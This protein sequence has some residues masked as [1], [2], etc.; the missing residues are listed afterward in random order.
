M[1]RTSIKAQLFIAEDVRQELD[2]KLSLIGF[3]S[4]AVIVADAGGRKIS[5]ESPIGL[6][7]ITFLVT[8]SH[9]PEEVKSFKVQSELV[10]VDGEAKA[11]SKDQIVE[12]P[13]RGRSANLIYALMPIAFTG[14]GMRAFRVRVDD[15]VFDLPYEFRLMN[16]GVSSSSKVGAAKAA[17]KKVKAALPKSAR[18]SSNPQA[19]A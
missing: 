1:A 8:L 2:G 5:P 10:G 14:A 16:Q 15:A 9:L 19:L 4:D 13:G 18:K 11:L 7:S 3:F 12:N 17:A 6:R